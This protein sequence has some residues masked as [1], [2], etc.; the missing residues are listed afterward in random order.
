LR[1]IIFHAAARNIF[2]PGVS[3]EKDAVAA[4]RRDAEN[5]AAQGGLSSFLAA[6]GKSAGLASNHFLVFRI[7]VSR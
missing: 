5:S 1:F 2:P 7:L 3:E 6:C 4:W